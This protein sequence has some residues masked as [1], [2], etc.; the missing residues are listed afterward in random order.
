MIFMIYLFFLA[1]PNPVRVESRE[2]KERTVTI[3]WAPAFDGGRPITEYYIDL[4]SKEGERI[5]S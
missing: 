3:R 4:K 2:V 1:R 5:K